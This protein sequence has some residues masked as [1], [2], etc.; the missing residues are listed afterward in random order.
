[1]KIPKEIL[2]APMNELMCGYLREYFINNGYGTVPEWTNTGCTFFCYMDNKTCRDVKGKV[3][4]VKLEYY[5]IDD[6]PL[7]RFNIVIYD[8]LDQPLEFDAFL[9]IGDESC[10][11]ILDALMIQEWIIFHWYGED[12]KYKGSTGVHWR[13]ENRKCVKDIWRK[14]KILI[15]NLKNNE[16]N[17]MEYINIFNKIKEKWIKENPLN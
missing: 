2:Q 10:R 1:M 4:N 15:D 6:Y 16:V 11:Y 9:N 12:F 14:G 17:N 5:E 3:H 7:I 13:E 8:R